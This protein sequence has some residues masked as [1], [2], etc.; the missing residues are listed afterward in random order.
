[1]DDD[2][3]N[4]D[5]VFFGNDQYGQWL[6]AYYYSQLPSALGLSNIDPGQYLDG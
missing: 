6:L 4:D 2:D 1:M 5:L 3:K